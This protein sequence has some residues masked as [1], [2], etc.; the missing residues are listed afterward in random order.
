MKKILLFLIL[1][2]ILNAN[3]YQD[4]LKEQDTQYTSYK[5]T[6]DEEFSKSLKEDW[7]RFNS[8][9]NTNP[10]KEKKPKTLPK[11]KKEIKVKKIEIKESKK[12]IVK[13]LPKKIINKVKH[14]EVKKFKN[15]K[16]LSFSFYW[17]TS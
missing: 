8:L 13:E 15:S 17:Y 5:K 1:T 14:T 3:A 12:I 9:Y 10:Y 6:F 7:S 2:I 4:W 11:I 16:M